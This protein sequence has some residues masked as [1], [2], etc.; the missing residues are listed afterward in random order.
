MRALVLLLSARGGETGVVLEEALLVLELV[1]GGV[2]HRSKRRGL[3]S[4]F[5]L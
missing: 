1:G 4:C 3:P 5:F 2:P